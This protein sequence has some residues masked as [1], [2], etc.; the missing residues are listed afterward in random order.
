MELTE[1]VKELLIKTANAL[2]GGNKRDADGAEAFLEDAPRSR[3]W[4]A[5]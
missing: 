2:K 5:S 4:P 1:E 3:A